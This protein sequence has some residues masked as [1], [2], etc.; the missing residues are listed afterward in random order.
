MRDDRDACAGPDE[1]RSGSW[2]SVRRAILFFGLL[3]CAWM[4]LTGRGNIYEYLAL[5]VPVI[6]VL[7]V[8]GYL[9]LR[10]KRRQP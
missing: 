10:T 3:G 5:G 6:A 8:I 4:V 2:R 1:L 9:K 7:V